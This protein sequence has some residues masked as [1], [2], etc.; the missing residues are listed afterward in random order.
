M[1][2]MMRMSVYIVVEAVRR[3]GQNTDPTAGTMLMVGGLG[4]LVNLVALF[5]LRG[6][7][8]ESLNVKGAYL[9]VLADTLGSVG[10]IVAAL[11]VQWTGDGWWD[12]LVALAIAVF[13]FVRAIFL[14]REVL[15]VLGQHAPAGTDP[16]DLIHA[17]EQVPGVVAVHDLHSWT[18]TSGMDMATPRGRP[19]LPGG[20][21]PSRPR[22]AGTVQHRPRHLAGR[23]PERRTVW[24]VSW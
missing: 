18:L 20:V 9:E 15:T 3:L 19:G 11:L 16:G 7:A 24:G 22:A 14:A 17:L 8:A 23:R 1:L 4:L 5:M 12:T 21:D 6:G 13:V 10:V 2:V